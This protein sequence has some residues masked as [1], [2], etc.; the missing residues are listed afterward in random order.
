M[1]IVERLIGEVKVGKKRQPELALFLILKF[2]FLGESGYRQALGLARRDYSHGT[3]KISAST[4]V[5]WSMSCG[6]TWN[7][8]DIMVLNMRQ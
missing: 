1:P 4:L 6:S 7:L 3:S 5:G 8:R 2:W